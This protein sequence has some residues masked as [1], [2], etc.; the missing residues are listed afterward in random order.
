MPLKSITSFIYFFTF[1]DCLFDQNTSVVKEV[2]W[3]LFAME[4]AIYCIMLHSAETSTETRLSKCINLQ[5]VPQK[6]RGAVNVL[7]RSVVSLIWK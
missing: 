7:N 2:Y 4:H 5:K 3:T 6:I 1:Y